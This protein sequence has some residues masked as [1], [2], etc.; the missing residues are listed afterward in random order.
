[1]RRLLPALIVTILITYL[2]SML[3]ITRSEGEIANTG[4]YSILGISNLYLW[5]L[6]SDY[7]GIAAL[8]NPFTHTWS[9]GV[10]EQFYFLYPLLILLIFKL[11]KKHFRV[12]VV[13]PIGA[14]T[15]GSISLAIVFSGTEPNLVF[16]SMPTRLWEFG[17]GAIAF[18][19]VKKEV[20]ASGRLHFLRVVAFL[21]LIFT[22]FFPHLKGILG[23]IVVVIATSILLVIQSH[24][25]IAKFLSRKSLAWIG[26][27]SY[28]LY[29]VHWPVLVITNYLFGND[30]LK[31]AI[32]IPVVMLLSNFM[33]KKIETPFRTGSLKTNSNRT[34]SIGLLVVITVY[35]SLHFIGPRFSQSYNK[36]I[37]N[38]LGISQVPNWISSPCSG[39]ENIS[40]LQ[41]PLKECLGGSLGN[42]ERF[43]YLIGDSH[44]D[45][46]IPMA[47][48]SFQGPKFVLKNLNLENGKDFPFSEFKYRSNSASLKFIEKFGK[49]GD[50]VILTFH[51]GHL[52]PKRDTHI[53][54][55]EKILPNLETQNLISNLNNFAK[56]ASKKGIKI[57]LIEDTPLMNSI[58]TSES[59]AVQYKLLRRD[60]CSVTKIQD[61]HTRFLQSFA[62]HRIE[63]GNDNVIVWDPFDYIYSNRDSFGSFKRNGTYTMWDWNHITPSFSFELSENFS[64]SIKQFIE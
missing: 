4:K 16:Y 63:K 38:L 26:V 33:F 1:M 11:A 20:S 25:Y 12:L 60:G 43:V 57:I 44:A 32:C 19:T 62:F 61:L 42:S 53:S 5:H 56:V 36:V 23:Q 7:F 35:L 2:V 27:R 40:K 30:L 52:N 9:L 3:I 45:Q 15:I 50:I 41:K 13:I 37:P 17:L 6:S 29:L 49:S 21:T 47:K 39:A 48:K 8:N 55:K 51:R 34:I 59:C 24:D 58:Q 10:E 28:S 22:L 14:L 31:N 64:N 18:F 46:F 54:V